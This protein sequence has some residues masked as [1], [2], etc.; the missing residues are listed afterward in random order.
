MNLDGLFKSRKRSGEAMHDQFPYMY[1]DRKTNFFYNTSSVGFGFDLTPLPYANDSVV[2]GIN[3]LLCS[4]LPEGN[5]WDYQI[6]LKST[7][8]INTVVE[9]NRRASS[10]FG[11]V[12]EK[13]ANNQ[14]IYNN[15]GA[16]HGFISSY[17]EQAK[18]DLREYQATIF[19]SNRKGDVKKLADLQESLNIA[20]TQMGIHVEPYKPEHLL[21]KV[22]DNLNFSL[23]AV[24]Q[25]QVQYNSLEELYKQVLAPD[26]EFLVHDTNIECAFTNERNKRES[27][28]I[29]TLGLQNLPHEFH[30]FRLPNCFSDI[31]NYSR[32]IQCPFE[33]S[34]NFQILDSGKAQ[35]ENDTNLEKQRKWAKTPI[36]K[37]IPDLPQKIAEAE[38][39]QK[40]LHSQ[41]C[42]TAKMSFTLTLFSSKESFKADKKAALNAFQNESLRLVPND[43]CHAA[44]FLSTFPFMGSDGYFDDLERLRLVRTVKTSNLAN[45]LPLVSDPYSYGI[46][47]LL[48]TFRR[49]LYFFDP[50]NCGSDNFN[51][52]IAAASGSG[53]SFLSQAIV[54]N[55]LER[56]GS[57]WILDKGSSYKKTAKIFGGTYMTIKDITL[58]PFTHLDEI[59]KGDNFTDENGDEINPLKVVIS[60]IVN[61]FIIIASPNTQVEQHLKIAMMQAI[62][63]AYN[64]HKSKTLVDHVQEELNII[65]KD[66]NDRGISNLAYNLTPFCTTGLFGDIFNKPSKLDPRIRLT[67]ME[68]DGF[69]DDLLQPAVYALM[70]NI[71]QAMYL[72]GERSKPKMCIIEEAWKLM[73]G[74]NQIA[75]KFIEEGYRT[76]R[77]FK[78]SFCAITQ[79]IRDFFRSAGAEAA[80]NNSDIKFYL[81]QG[82]GFDDYLTSHPDA[83]TPFETTMLKDFPTAQKAGFSSMLL[84]IGGMSS[85]HRYFCDPITKA[86]FNTDGAEVQMVEE[87]EK[88]GMSTEEAIMKTAQ[89]FHPEELELF[90]SIV[91]KHNEEQER[92]KGEY[93]EVA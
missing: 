2:E 69:S 8:R 17:N 86:M 50:F 14:A 78:G 75:A 47:L 37:L 88:E 35:V 66:R 67:V 76:A 92:M 85:F 74:E 73:T 53:K 27:V 40:G 31:Y 72:S 48:P 4:V 62:E 81:R 89:K 34:V 79:G 43:L 68:L 38:M 11:G 93:D 54:R 58:S 29:V 26:S 39:L 16:K 30:L 23:S 25:P 90:E 44:C 36:G 5:V 10:V 55:V 56:G 61:L 15:Y 12:Y 7:S 20:L 64:Q 41:K 91:A 46:G 83:F 80:Y 19:V 60:D 57:V 51:M 52:A 9:A 77:K 87:F 22:V 32:S 28:R 3:T 71:N 49:S 70:V 82:D 24:T 6:A 63:A 42:K 59:A 84:R 1:F 45:F 33:L 21:G 18:F 65:A 13:F